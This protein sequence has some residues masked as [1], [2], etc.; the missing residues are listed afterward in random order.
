MSTYEIQYIKQPEDDNSNSS[1]PMETGATVKESFWDNNLSLITCIAMILGQDINRIQKRNPHPLLYG[2][3]LGGFA[4][5]SFEV[6]PPLSILQVIL[7]NKPNNA[8]YY[9]KTVFDPML[10]LFHIDEYKQK[11]LQVLSYIQIFIPEAYDDVN[12]QP[13]I[14]IEVQAVFNKD[15]VL[16]KSWLNLS[17]I[18]QSKALNCIYPFSKASSLNE[19]RTRLRELKSKQVESIINQIKVLTNAGLGKSV[20]DELY[21][22]E[23]KEAVETLKKCGLIEGSTILDM[24]CGHGHYTI[25]ASIA[26]GENGCVIAVDLNK[27]VIRESQ[28]R[29]KNMNI[30]NVTFINTNESGLSNYIDKVD[31]LILY[32]VL[33]G[34][35]WTEN[36]IDKLKILYS[37]LRNGGILSLALYSEIE[38]KVPPNAKPTPKGFYST[39]PISHEEAIKPYI[40]LVESFGFKLNNIVENG[41]VHF[42]DFHSPYHWRKYGEVRISSLERRNIYNLIKL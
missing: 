21:E 35:E 38:R 41:G 13:H 17:S 33:H 40:E 28:N 36:K 23:T 5:E 12:W 15:K 22:F 7:K 42:D 4:F 39:V 32:D 24:G 18:Q 27:K 11:K 1:R 26:T 2:K 10:G 3:Y 6:L 14:P 19:N 8:V 9:N 20:W 30:S 16:E 29:I 34:G 31:F 25:P 37:L